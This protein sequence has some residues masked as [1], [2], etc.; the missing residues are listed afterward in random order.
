MLRVP[1]ITFWMLLSTADGTK[2]KRKETAPL[3]SSNDQAA[4]AHHQRG[5][6]AHVQGDYKGAIAAFREAI[7]A[8]PD[9]AYAYFRLGFVLHERRQRF[10][11]RK[12]EDPVPSFRYAGTRLSSTQLRYWTQPW[13][14]DSLMFW[15]RRLALKLDPSDESVHHALGQALQDDQRDAEAAAIFEAIATSL[16][17]RSARAY[18]ALG[19]VRAKNIDEWDSDPDDPNDPSHY[20]AQAARLQPAEFQEDG[21][22]VRRVEP[23]TPEREE[24]EERE[25]HERRQRILTELKD[26][27]RKLSYADELPGYRESATTISATQKTSKGRKGREEL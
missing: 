7:N 15:Q 24:R 26:G 6:M 11:K 22:R 27:T 21:S 5:T 16:N 20:Y 10:P 25:A 19:K 1:C 3:T 4:M 17:P 9:F 2:R 8:K 13:L 23:M 18:W 14:T 12:S